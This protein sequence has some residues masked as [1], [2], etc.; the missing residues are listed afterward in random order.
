MVQ[1]AGRLPGIAEQAQTDPRA[2]ELRKGLIDFALRGGAEVLRLCI[3]FVRFEFARELPNA[4]RP[5]VAQNKLTKRCDAEDRMQPT[6]L[7]ISGWL[8][9][10]AENR[11]GRT[12]EETW[13]VKSL[14]VPVRRPASLPQPAWTEAAPGRCPPR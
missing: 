1:D 12:R 9:V 4:L 10:R 14:R 13:G 11:D 3:R 2:V 8:R 5:V 6:W 7:R